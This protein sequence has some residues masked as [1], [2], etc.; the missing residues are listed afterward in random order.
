LH[1][2]GEQILKLRMEQDT[3]LQMRNMIDSEDDRREMGDLF[4]EIFGG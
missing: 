4:D 3:L 1:D 2:L